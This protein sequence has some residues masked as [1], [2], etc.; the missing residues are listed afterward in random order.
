MKKSRQILFIS[1]AAVLV[2]AITLTVTLTV[3]SARRAEE[4][5]AAVSLAYRRLSERAASFTVTVTEGG[6]KVDSYT[7]ATAWHGRCSAV[8]D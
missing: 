4:E 1:L 5:H 2:L 6:T 8:R 3:R 7:L